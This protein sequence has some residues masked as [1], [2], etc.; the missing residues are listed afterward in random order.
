MHDWRP[1]RACTCDGLLTVVI[2][3]RELTDETQGRATLRRTVAKAGMPGLQAAPRL[4]GSVVKIGR[5]KIK[6]VTISRD[7][8][9]AT[10]NSW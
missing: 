9:I 7:A 10:K 3:L 5:A 1:E 2:E 6:S 4:G 8:F